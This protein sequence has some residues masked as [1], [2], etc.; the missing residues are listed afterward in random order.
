[1]IDSRSYGVH[2]EAIMPD[3]LQCLRFAAQGYA[4]LTTAQVEQ[5]ARWVEADFASIGLKFELTAEWLPIS[6]DQRLPYAGYRLLGSDCDINKAGT[7]DRRV[8]AMAGAGFDQGSLLYFSKISEWA[9]QHIPHLWPHKF[10]EDLRDPNQHNN[11]LC[12]LWWL[13]KVVGLVDSSVGYAVPV[14]PSRPKSKNIDWLAKTTADVTLR[15][16]V[17]RRPGDVGRFIGDVRIKPASLFDAVDK[18]K[19]ASPPE[20]LNIGCIQLFGPINRDVRSVVR[21]WLQKSPNVSAVAL[22]APCTSLDETFAV[23]TQPTLGYIEH[24]FARPDSEDLAYFAPISFALSAEQLQKYYPGLELP[25]I[26]Q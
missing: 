24:F 25:T 8:V 7:G 19:P 2:Q 5:R 3:I 22:Y 18:F 17:K 11:T 23:I 21:D 6:A 15:L 10:K 20:S 4:F 9:H 14:E 1:M 16:E 12:E 26:E 13:S